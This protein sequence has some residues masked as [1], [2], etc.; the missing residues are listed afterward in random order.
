MINWGRVSLS[1]SF[2]HFASGGSC[3]CTCQTSAC[4]VGTGGDH[5]IKGTILY[6]GCADAYAFGLLDHIVSRRRL[7]LP[8]CL[9]VFAM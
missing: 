1:T 3:V 2:V 9:V 8:S 7:S 6:R 4:V 5:A